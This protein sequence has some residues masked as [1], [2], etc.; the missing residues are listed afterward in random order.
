MTDPRELL[1]DYVR[2]RS[3]PAFREIVERYYDLVHS[4]AARRVRGR[5][6]LARDVAQT[7]FMDLTRQASKLPPDVQLGGWLHRHT[8]FVTS[9][10]I[11]EEQ[12]RRTREAQAVRMNPREPTTDAAFA[13]IAP[14]L[15][16]AIEELTESDRTAIVLR[17]FER[18]EFR[19][20]GETLATTEDAA[21]MRVSRAVD[22]L[23]TILTGRGVTIS[24]VALTALLFDHS[25]SAAPTGAADQ[26]LTSIASKS[27][28][29]LATLKLGSLAA[30]GAVVVAAGIAITL[31][32]TRQASSAPSTAPAPT[33]RAAVA[34]AP[35]AST[36]VASLSGTKGMN[37][38]GVMMTDGG[39]RKVSGTLPATFTTQGNDVKFAFQISGKG[40]IAIDVS[41]NGKRLGSSNTGAAPFG[42]VLATFLRGGNTIDLF[43]TF[44][45]DDDPASALKGR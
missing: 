2:N 20:V 36:F 43:T 42:G 27:A 45:K 8:C 30:G 24:A 10:M 1:A 6:E 38:K 17:F 12:R 31:A 19:A 4:T 26:V 39:T 40:R 34:T 35:S 44:D 37:F 16:E 9:K 25:V 5:S 29:H 7:V 3:H 21:R 15:D 14:L 32:V 13:E 41:E 11:R 33:T 22:R 28:A 18:R 23:R